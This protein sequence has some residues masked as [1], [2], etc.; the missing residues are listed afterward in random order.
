MLCIY[1]HSTLILNKDSH[2]VLPHTVAKLLMVKATTQIVHMQI[3]TGF[4]WY[5]LVML[6]FGNYDA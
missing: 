1:L 5:F 4:F 3:G 6:F 2:L